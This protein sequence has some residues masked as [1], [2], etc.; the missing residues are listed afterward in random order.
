MDVERVDGR[1]GRWD[2]LVGVFGREN[3]NVNFIREQ[4]DLDRR[5]YYNF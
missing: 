2:K 1:K 5:I 3:L 4:C